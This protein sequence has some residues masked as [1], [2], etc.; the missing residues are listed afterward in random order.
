MLTLVVGGSGSGKSEY[1]ESLLE[2][3]KFDKV[4]LATMQPFGAEGKRRIER[5]R[6]MRKN[7][8]FRTVEKYTDVGDAEV[9]D[10][11][12]LLECLTNLAANEM[13]SDGEIKSTD[14]LVNK[15]VN[16]IKILYNKNRDM[17]VVSGSV[18]CD[19]VEYSEK[20]QQYIELIG[21]L[22]TELGIIAD[23]VTEVV[24]GIALAVKG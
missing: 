12:V 4:Y 7:K 13:F 24:C 14:F 16:D 21:R 11:F 17:V 22:N 23:R 20:T 1:A 3:C 10:C 19:G 15:L 5:H 2:S 9:R 8:G 18:D 6:E